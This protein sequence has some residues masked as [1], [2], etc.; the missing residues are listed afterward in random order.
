MI[1]EEMAVDGDLEMLNRNRKQ[2]MELGPEKG[3]HKPGRGRKKCNEPRQK[4]KGWEGRKFAR[5][6]VRRERFLRAYMR[7]LTAHV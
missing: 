4:G 2:T 5:C 3:K 7:A 1:Q 6:E